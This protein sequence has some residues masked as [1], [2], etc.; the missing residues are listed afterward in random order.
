MN[1][2]ENEIHTVQNPLY[3]SPPS[4]EINNNNNNK[5]KKERRGTWSNFS[6]EDLDTVNNT[7]ET[8]KLNNSENNIIIS[9]NPIFAPRAQLV[10]LLLSSDFEVINGI[11]QVVLV[12]EEGKMLAEALLDFFDSH[13]KIKKLIEW[14]I[15]KEILHTSTPNTLFRGS[16]EVTKLMAVLYSRLG[17]DYLKQIV[18]P[19]VKDITSSGGLD[20]SN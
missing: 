15:I 6:K 2:K 13:G 3:R 12:P 1:I 11:C 5:F 16:S 9:H 19:L 7:G 4:Q 20:R 10:E 8:N 14:A 18:G 17:R